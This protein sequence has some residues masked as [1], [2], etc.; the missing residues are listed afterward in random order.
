MMGLEG[1]GDNNDGFSN[2]YALAMP[3][4]VPILLI[5]LS[6]ELWHSYDLNSMCRQN[7]DLEIAGEA[8]VSASR[9]EQYRLF[10]I[11]G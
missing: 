6:V 2:L 8:C 7:M 4:L 11:A 10:Y 9:I 3:I 1:L 5:S